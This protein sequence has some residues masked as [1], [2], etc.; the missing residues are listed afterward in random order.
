V[1]AIVS[2][3]PA[4]EILA[5]V[6]ADERHPGRWPWARLAV[7]ADRAGLHDRARQLLSGPPPG[8][9]AGFVLADVV[10]A[11]VGDLVDQVER[12]AAARSS[13]SA[14]GASS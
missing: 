1:V 3:A 5:E 8:M 6:Q 11:F 14:A 10:A 12:D 7:H 4:A 9:P 13:S 2:R